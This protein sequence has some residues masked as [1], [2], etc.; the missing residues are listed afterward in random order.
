MGTMKHTFAKVIELETHQVLVVKG[1]DYETGKDTITISTRFDG[2]TPSMTLGFGSED[3][4]DKCWSGYDTEQ[5][6][7]FVK[8]IT[9]M[10]HP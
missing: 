7:A 4:A 2:V 10:M 3:D 1:W 8:S 9:D 5:A 6:Q